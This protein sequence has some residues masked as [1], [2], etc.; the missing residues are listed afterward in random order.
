MRDLLEGNLHYRVNLANGP[1]TAE[2]TDKMQATSATS[3]KAFAA[4][5][6]HGSGLDSS[7]TML[8]GRRTITLHTEWHAMSEHGYYTGYYPVRVVLDR[9]QGRLSLRSVRVNARATNDAGDYLA[10][11]FVD[12]CKQANPPEGLAAQRDLAVVRA[13]AESRQ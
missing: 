4:M 13:Y 1:D 9:I 10:D 7:Y 5:L 11:V 8:W 3:L 2:A 6:P 12:V